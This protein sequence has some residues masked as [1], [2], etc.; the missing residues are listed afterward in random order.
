MSAILIDY[1]NI[2]HDQLLKSLPCSNKSCMPPKHRKGFV[3]ALIILTDK[4]T[5]K[6]IS[7]TSLG[8][9]RVSFINSPQFIIKK[10]YYI[11]YNQKK[12]ICVLDPKCVTDISTVL[13]SLFTGLPPE[14]ILWV[15]LDI[16]DNKFTETLDIFIDNSFNSP[17]ITVLSPL[18]DDIAPSVALSR[19]NIRELSNNTNS[20][21]NKVLQVMEQY[22]SNEKV[23][24]L[25]SRLSKNAVSF[26]RKTSMMGIKV[27]KNGKKTQ[28]ELTGELYVK[29]VVSENGTFVYVID[30]NKDSVES[31]EEEAVDVS[32]TRYNFHSHPHQAYVNHS[33]EYAWPSVTDYLGYLQLGD[34]TIFHCVATLEGLY[35]ISFTAHWG[36]NLKNVSKSFVDKTFEI[37]HK[38]PYTPEEYVEKVNNILYKGHPIYNLKFF[39]W[40]NAGET[41]KVFF[42]QIG[43][44][45]LVSQKIVENYRKIH[46]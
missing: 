45:C 29:D 12:G 10:Y 43:S 46:S 28:K 33:V 38:E 35:I 32:D 21:L 7:N 9:K 39:K 11:M 42:P 6:K 20:S 5:L 14:T 27:G 25:H 40:E 22:K 37:D 15:P 26:L 18:Y 24:F 19:R 30:I 16:R 1:V 13:E 23:C 41:F 44:S 3:P 2:K 36:Q 17:Y 4:E 34:S 31:G 8:E